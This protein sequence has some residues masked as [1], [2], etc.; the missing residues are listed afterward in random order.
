MAKKVKTR[1]NKGTI[2]KI[3]SLIMVVAAIIVPIQVYLLNILPTVYLVL[4]SIILISIALLLFIIRNFKAKGFGRFLCSVLCFVLCVGFVFGNVYIYKTS[5]M[6]KEITNLT[7][8]TANTISVMVLKN[9][10]LESE[11]DLEGK[12]VGI[13][14]GLDPEGCQ[15]ALDDLEGI[16]FEKVEYDDVFTCAD[17]LYDGKLDAMILNESYFGI[18]HDEERFTLFTTETK[19]I[20]QS[21]YYTDRQNVMDVTDD[22]VDV[23]A[24]PFTVLICGNDSYGT[25]DETS[26]CDV[27]MLVTI[28]PQ[29]GTILMTSIPRDYYV[30]L[31]GD[32]E[33]VAV[34]SKDKLTHTGLSGI[35]TTEATLEEM[36][37]ININYTARVN[38]SSLV[39][40][41]D[42]LGG[43]DVEVGKGLAV[44][45]FYAN[46]TL[47][48]VHEGTNHLDG[49]RALAFARERHAYIDGD[50]QRV[51]NQQIV[52]KAII[53]K[54]TSPS[55]IVRYGDFV[56]AIGGAFETDMPSEDIQDFIRFEI[57][58]FPKWKFESY[59]LYGY[60]STE[61]CAQLGGSAYVT[62][63][64]PISVECASQKIN[65]VE[66]GKSSDTIQEEDIEVAEEENDD[67]YV[68]NYGYY[69]QGYGYY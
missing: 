24:Q 27:N 20:H 53:N 35:Q 25:L 58:H 6:M 56:D 33:Y 36:L 68:Q 69:N 12:R 65:A 49:E 41:V 34:G 45:T 30:T 59:S 3:I 8:K 60:G 38:F 11:Q 62:I 29:T 15:Y 9:S 23:D 21:V 28:N 52:L 14:P 63:P 22:R 44:D 61:Y 26:R 10:S 16:S 43:I 47:E 1:K 5:Q 46:N 50:N 67:T 19:Q 31:A 54:M 40:L 48:G 32:E 17:D 55:M 37:N 13:M 2:G 42:A 57:S 18:L 4:I 64:E 51:I 7:T 39:N 66:N